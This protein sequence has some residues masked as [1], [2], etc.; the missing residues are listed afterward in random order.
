[1]DIKSAT[2]Q[3]AYNQ[4]Q[5]DR[6]L[7]GIGLGA[8]DYRRGESLA[9]DPYRALEADQTGVASGQRR[10]A[11]DVRAAATAS[12][13]M[14]IALAERGVVAAKADEDRKLGVA[15]QGIQSAARNANSQ[16][17]TSWDIYNATSARDDANRATAKAESDAK[18]KQND[19]IGVE[20]AKLNNWWFVLSDGTSVDFRPPLPSDP[21]GAAIDLVATGL[22]TG[23]PAGV[24]AGAPA[25]ALTPAPLPKVKPYNFAGLDGQYSG[26][27]KRDAVFI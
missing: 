25:P 23:A 18:D 4:S 2:G 9:A 22:S 3:E 26:N 6:N 24:P 10:Y 1:L 7:E 21:E 13:E 12:E 19:S 27:V 11:Q 16:N 15:V 5:L 8:M 14:K 20:T 17:D